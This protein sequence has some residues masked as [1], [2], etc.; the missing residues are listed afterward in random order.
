MCSF[1]SCL[2][3]CSLVPSLSWYNDRFIILWK[4]GPKTVVVFS[5]AAL[6]PMPPAPT[7]KIFFPLGET[8]AMRSVTS[9]RGISAFLRRVSVLLCELLRQMLSWSAARA[10]SEVA[11]VLR[12]CA[13]GAVSAHHDC[14]PPTRAGGRGGAQWA[15]GDVRPTH[16][17][18]AGQYA[19]QPPRRAVVRL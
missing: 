13:R 18:R 15:L 17:L 2:C 5:P 6:H 14:C 16:R 10:R 3:A 1:L 8:P 19:T 9:D 12:G 11:R 4:K 7:T